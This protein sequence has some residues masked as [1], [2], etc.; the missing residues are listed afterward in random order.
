[1]KLRFLLGL[2]ATTVTGTLALGQQVVIQ[3]F[4]TPVS[5]G[6]SPTSGKPAATDFKPDANTS[7]DPKSLDVPADVAKAAAELLKK[8]GS[9]TYKDRELASKE[10][11]KLWRQAVPVLMEGLAS[12]NPE[13]V[14]RAEALL[15]KAQ[16]LDM[17]AR[18]A[19]FLADTEGKY[20]HTLPG[21]GRFRETAGNSKAS[22]ELFAEALKNKLTHQMLLAAEGNPEDAATILSSYVSRLQGYANRWGGSYEQ[23]VS[24][25][26]ADLAIALF[27]EAQYTD[28]EV[29]ITMPGWGWGGGQ[30]FSVATNLYNTSDFS[31]AMRSSPSGKYAEPIR[32]V[33]QR[34]MDSRE[35]TQGLNQAWTF[36]QQMYGA[37]P[38]L[39]YGVKMLGGE[40]SPNTYYLK[41]NVLSQ[42]GQ[43]NNK[44]FI[45]EVAKHCFDDNYTIWGMQNGGNPNHDIQMRDYALAVVLQMTDQNPKEYGF[46]STISGAGGPKSK[47][48]QY[49]TFYFKDERSDKERGFDPNNPNAGRIVRRGGVVVKEGDK[50]KED[51]KKDDKKDD[52]AKKPSAEDKRKAAFKKWADWSAVNI[53]DGKVKEQPKKEEP[54]KEEPKASGGKPTDKPAVEP[55]K[56]A[57]AEAAARDAATKAEAAKKD[58]VKKDEEA[59]KEEPKKEEPKKEGPKK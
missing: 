3:K 55:K 5:S 19:C 41:Q 58:A 34:W 42:L 44:E 14:E 7:P 43:N 27:L 20:E 17:K 59:K 33:V 51:E 4:A 16:Q 11:V 40:T 9:P 38:A 29:V 12:D 36:A 52:K 2:A 49:N 22:R 35:T 24:A 30:Y 1:M 8:L 28:K 56:E 47:N 31:N 18:V 13:V 10:L 46:D 21:W 48:W 54:K 32:K 39:K 25:K 50:K 15:P 37:K 53:V 26:T 57:A 23:P 45:A 6:P